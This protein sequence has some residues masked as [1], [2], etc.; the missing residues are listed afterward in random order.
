MNTTPPQVR[1]Y[2]ELVV[3]R[4]AV[5]RFDVDKAFDEATDWASSDAH[6]AGLSTTAPRKHGS[7]NHQRPSP[8]KADAWEA[9]FLQVP[10]AWRA[11]GPAHAQP[12]I[13]VRSSQAQRGAAALLLS[14]FEGIVAMTSERCHITE[15]TSYRRRYHIIR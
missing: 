10:R 1:R 2:H 12:A 3:N 7:Q 11:L 13:G 4:D 14:P 8:P 6:G 9:N 5:A 15:M